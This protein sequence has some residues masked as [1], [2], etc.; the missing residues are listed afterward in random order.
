MHEGCEHPDVYL[1]FILTQNL[2]VDT[3]FLALGSSNNAWNVTRS[4]F[5]ALLLKH[6]AECGARVFTQTKV[7]F[8][9]F[10]AQADSG[11]LNGDDGTSGDA[12]HETS[13]RSR[14]GS[15]GSLGVGFEPMGR[16]VKARYTAADGSKGEITFKYFIDASGRAGLLST[17]CAFLFLYGKVV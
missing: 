9:E 17:K 14:S 2:S 4:E 3:D 16:P 15:V 11:E 13:S 10:V 12:K 1:L 5:D 6:A 8:L 7:D